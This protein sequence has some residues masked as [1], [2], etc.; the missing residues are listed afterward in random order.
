[1]DLVTKQI[2]VLHRVRAKKQADT[3]T[4]YHVTGSFDLQADRRGDDSGAVENSS[5]ARVSIPLD[6]AFEVAEG[7]YI[8]PGH[9][10]AD[11]PEK[12]ISLRRERGGVTVT[13]VRRLAYGL[14]M[15]GTYSRYASIVYCEGR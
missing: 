13:H 3:F 6:Q 1:M 11:T 7:D 8:V 4:A 2:T 15:T 14:G 5:T 10:S 12:A 9:V